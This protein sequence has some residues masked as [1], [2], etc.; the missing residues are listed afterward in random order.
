M[1]LAS[2]VTSN[3]VLARDGEVVTQPKMVTQT[4]HPAE[5][6]RPMSQDKKSLMQTHKGSLTA[7]FV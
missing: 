4:L 5:I 2:S 3:S 7:I 1:G 6:K